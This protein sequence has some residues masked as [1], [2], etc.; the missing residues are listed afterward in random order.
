ML[1]TRRSFS[2]LPWGSRPRW[3]T[4]AAT[5]SMALAFLQAATQAPQPMH[6]AASIARS[7]SSL[8]TGSALASGAPPVFTETKPPAWMM[9]SK[10]R[11]VHDQVLDDRERPGRARARW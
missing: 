9:R 4:L 8:G 10:A 5:N 1:R 6:A 11:A 2:A 7:A 3:E